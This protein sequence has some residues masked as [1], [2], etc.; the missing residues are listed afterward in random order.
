M[1]RLICFESQSRPIAAPRFSAGQ[2]SN[3]ARTPPV[4]QTTGRKPEGRASSPRGVPSLCSNFR[5]HSA[6]TSASGKYFRNTTDVI[7][8]IDTFRPRRQSA[9]LRGGPSHGTFPRLRQPFLPFRPRLAG[10]PKATPP[11][12]AVVSAMPGM[13]LAVVG[14]LPVLCRTLE[15]DV[16]RPPRAVHV[17]PS[18]VSHASCRLVQPPD[19]IRAITSMLSLAARACAT[20]FAAT[21]SL[22]TR[23]ILRYTRPPMSQLSRRNLLKTA[24][25]GATMAALP[26]LSSASSA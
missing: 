13:R 5:P 11:G 17:L 12:R 25:S 21:E 14:H 1:S 26:S 20:A 3:D 23:P 19:V 22:P 8:V 4:L 24:I 18:P 9:P 6:S 16:A 10:S 15:R 2:A 7:G